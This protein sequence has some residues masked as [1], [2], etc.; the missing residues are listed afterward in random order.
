MTH[1][2]NIVFVLKVHEENGGHDW[3]IKFITLIIRQG[4]LAPKDFGIY[5]CIAKGDNTVAKKEVI[6]R[7][8]KTANDDEG[9]EIIN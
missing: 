2:I 1:Y 6:L 3:P 7:E 4:V 5:S 8:R 9:Y